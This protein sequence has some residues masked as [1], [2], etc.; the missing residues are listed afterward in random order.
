MGWSHLQ[1]N[2]QIL[3]DINCTFNNNHARNNGGAIYTKG[4][5]TE[6]NSIY[7]GNNAY[8]G[9][10]I[11]NDNTLTETTAYSIKTLQ[12]RMMESILQ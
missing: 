1:C 6:T 11:Y 5:L 2:V 9:G 12:T 7:T 3:N 4:N 8:E 10:A